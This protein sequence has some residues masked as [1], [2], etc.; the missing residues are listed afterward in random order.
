[1][2]LLLSYENNTKTQKEKLILDKK[3]LI[4]NADMDE[5]MVGSFF[6]ILRS[7][8]LNEKT[9]AGQYKIVESYQK[10]RSKNNPS[11]DIKIQKLYVELE[12]YK[13]MRKEVFDCAY[14]FCNKE[15]Q[16][17]KTKKRMD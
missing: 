2:N 8:V 5:N 4:K 10:V 16:K 3:N 13:H 1:M 9:I 6:D 7:N 17:I 14:N 12:I 15:K 11:F